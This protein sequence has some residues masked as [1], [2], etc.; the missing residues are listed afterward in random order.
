[1]PLEKISQYERA[2]P[3]SIKPQL[4]QSLLE[5]GGNERKIE[6][7]TFLKESALPYL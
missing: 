1:M 3:K 5:K 4:L 6:P 7:D 2:I